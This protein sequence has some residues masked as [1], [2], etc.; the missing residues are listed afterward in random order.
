MR[1]TL[2]IACDGAAFTSD[3]DGDASHELSRI[4]AQ[5]AQRIADCGM[6][7]VNYAAPIRDV[8]GNACGLYAFTT[9]D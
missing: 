7:E 6:P 1:F 4:L 9:E 3:A 5:L 8:N 2:D